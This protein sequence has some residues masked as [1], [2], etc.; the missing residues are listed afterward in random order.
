MAQG[1]ETALSIG[2][3]K[4]STDEMYAPY[5]Q[6]GNSCMRSRTANQGHGIEN[7][8]Y[9]LDGLWKLTAGV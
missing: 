5:L 3:M 9:L 7:V 6:P 1:K 8:H 2:V 4:M